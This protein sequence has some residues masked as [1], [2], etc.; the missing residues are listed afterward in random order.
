MP[1][2]VNSAGGNRVGLL[3][4]KFLVEWKVNWF[5]Q[6]VSIQLEAEKEKS[7]AEWDCRQD[8]KARTDF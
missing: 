8:N 2:W 5:G 7:E 4:S 3:N 1:Y 6:R